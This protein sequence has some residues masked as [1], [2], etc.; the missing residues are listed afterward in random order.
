MYKKLKKALQTTIGVG[1]LGSSIICTVP[2]L[3]RNANKCS[4][5][6][7]AP[8]PGVSIKIRCGTERNKY[9]CWSR[10]YNRRIK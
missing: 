1:M 7:N 5:A 9:V 3:A 6:G 4:W 8:T 2:V 10:V